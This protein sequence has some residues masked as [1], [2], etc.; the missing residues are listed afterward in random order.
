MYFQMT[1][2]RCTQDRV[3][4]LCPIQKEMDL[5]IALSLSLTGL[6][7]TTRAWL[8]IEPKSHIYIAG[9]CPLQFVF[10]QKRFF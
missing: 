7:E 1:E 4:V 8:R 3:N 6:R 2:I 5:E 9:T 10:V